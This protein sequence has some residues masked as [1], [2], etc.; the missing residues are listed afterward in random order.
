MHHVLNI[1]YTQPLDIVDT[2]RPD[3]AAWIAEEIEAGRLI[4]AGRNEHATG[5]VLISGD[6]SVEEA[7]AL[8]AADP[9]T[10]AGVA[11]YARTGF[12]VSFKGAGIP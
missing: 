4:L 12:T 8:I 11:E 5:G 9:Y 2:F 7:E 3:H 10:K 1:S 6:I